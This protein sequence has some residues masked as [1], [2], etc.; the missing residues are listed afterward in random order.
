MEFEHEL[1]HGTL[2]WAAGA[3]MVRRQ[4]PCR[5][6]QILVDLR[7]NTSLCSCFVQSCRLEFNKKLSDADEHIK[8]IEGQLWHPLHSWMFSSPCSRTASV[9][10]QGRTSGSM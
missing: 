7:V 2:V 9:S 3:H 6:G 10:R 4:M 1:R 5:S 8:R